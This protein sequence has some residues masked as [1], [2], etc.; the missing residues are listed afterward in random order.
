MARKTIIRGVVILAALLCV[1]LWWFRFSPQTEIPSVI[2]AISKI[3]PVASMPTPLPSEP[4]TI[5]GGP[6]VPDDPR[7][8]W[9]REQEKKTQVLNGKCRSAF[10]GR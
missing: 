3:T 10:T 6:Y 9:W 2:Q 7:W 1:L 5:P 8:K 4:K